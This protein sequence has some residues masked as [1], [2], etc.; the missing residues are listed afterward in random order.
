MKVNFQRWWWESLW[1]PGSREEKQQ[2]LEHVVCLDSSLWLQQAPQDWRSA[3]VGGLGFADWMKKV[4]QLQMLPVETRGAGVTCH[5]V[6]GTWQSKEHCESDSKLREERANRGTRIAGTHEIRDLKNQAVVTGGTGIWTQ[7][8]WLQNLYPLCSNP[9]PLW[10]TQ[11][12]KDMS[13]QFW[14]G[15]S[16][17]CVPW[18]PWW[19]ALE[20]CLY[21]VTEG[22]C[23]HTF[24]SS[25]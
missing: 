2:A 18:N 22:G 9:P 20:S 8:L 16:G 6:L 15:I 3:W 23:F 12:Y 4:K 7:D 10:V 17:V 14:Y 11:K 1:C 24:A 13:P 21:T 25:T 19:E 5:E